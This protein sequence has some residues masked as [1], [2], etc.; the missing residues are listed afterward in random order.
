MASLK[1]EVS[2]V[3]AQRLLQGEAAHLF[4]GAGYVWAVRSIEILIKEFILL[5]IFFE[6]SEGDWKK[7]WRQVR[8]TFKSADWNEAVRVVD[9][10]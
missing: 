10:N 3:T 1:A 5:S 8:R 2:L 6:Q 7:A 4:A 9:E